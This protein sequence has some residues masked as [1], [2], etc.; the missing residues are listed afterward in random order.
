M[1]RRSQ[2]WYF[3]KTIYTLRRLR[4]K[5][6]KTYRCRYFF[7]FY[8]NFYTY[9]IWNLLFFYRR[10]KLHV[11]NIRIHDGRIR[12]RKNIKI[13]YTWESNKTSSAELPMSKYVLISELPSPWTRNHQTWWLGEKKINK[14]KI[15][16]VRYAK[17][18]TS[19]YFFHTE[20]VRNG[21]F[22]ILSGYIFYGK[23][24]KKNV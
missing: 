3:I 12:R 19:F 24:K 8:V 16:A 11:Q 1:S 22:A 14:N 7:F 18:Q 15:I 5:Y 21:N 9:S 6:K 10:S 2:R 20:H 4:N 17:T 23:K 13:E